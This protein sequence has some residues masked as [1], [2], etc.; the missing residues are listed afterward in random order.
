MIADWISRLI[1][2]DRVEESPKTCLYRTIGIKM[3]GIKL[4]LDLNFKQ[5]HFVAI[6]QL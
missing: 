6:G 2:H 3:G 4:N 5:A 1:K